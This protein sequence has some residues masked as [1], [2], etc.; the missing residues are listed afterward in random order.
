MIVSVESGFFPVHFDISS[1]QRASWVTRDGPCGDPMSDDAK[2]RGDVRVGLSP[3]LEGEGILGDRWPETSFTLTLQGHETLEER[4]KFTVYKILVNGSQGTSW[5]IFRRYTDFCRLQNKLKD[6]F[7]RVHLVLP[8]KRW[9]KDNYDEEF[10]AERQTALQEFLHNMT[11]HK[12]LIS[13]Y[14]GERTDW[15]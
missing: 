1:L 15:H 6:L 11:H 8:P 12:N 2:S 14:C 3:P 9:F 5:M 4:A 10:L 7:P 13:R